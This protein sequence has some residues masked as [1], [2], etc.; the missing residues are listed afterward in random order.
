MALGFTLFLIFIGIALVVIVGRT[1][2]SLLLQ[3]A[4]FGG[5]A[6][7]IDTYIYYVSPAFNLPSPP[8]WMFIVI[9]SAF[10]FWALLK[11]SFVLSKVFPFPP[12]SVL[13]AAEQ[14]ILKNGH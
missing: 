5:M 8:S 13:G 4:F 3:L 6:G 7:L 14:V 2:K 10:A 1:I 11:V 12:F 9:S